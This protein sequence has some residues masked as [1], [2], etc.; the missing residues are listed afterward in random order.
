MLIYHVVDGANIMSVMIHTLMTWTYLHIVLLD[1]SLYIMMNL[2]HFASPEQCLPVLP[3]Y[4]PI[5]GDGPGPV[6]VCAQMQ[7]RYRDP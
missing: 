4:L 7:E 2:L 3:A 1:Q 5:C 6:H